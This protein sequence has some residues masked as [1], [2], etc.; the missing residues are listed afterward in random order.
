MNGEYTLRNIKSE[1]TSE[2]VVELLAI[3]QIHRPPEE[4][5][6]RGLA[7]SVDYA[8]SDELDLWGVD[9]RGE[10]VG[11]AGVE[12]Q[13]GG[14]LMLHDLAIWPEVRG[15]GV[16][17]MLVDFLHRQYADRTVRGYTMDPA[18]GFYRRCGFEVKEDGQM[19]SGDL[20][21][22]FTSAAPR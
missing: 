12:E 9:L 7:I 4:R 19:A 8:G 14:V 18:T 2:R 21:Y 16:G 10:V 13:S 5:P 20:R 6:A 22:E 1:A 17:R 15:E 3:A 11:L